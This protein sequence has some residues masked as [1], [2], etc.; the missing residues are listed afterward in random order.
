MVR[1]RGID[2]ALHLIGEGYASGGP[3]EVWARQERL[4][5]GVAFLGT[6]PREELLARMGRATVLAHASREEAFGMTLVEAMSQRLPVIAGVRSGA[7]PWVLGGGRAGMLVDVKDAGVLADA[8][9]AVLLQPER[10]EGLAR[11]GYEYAWNNY[12]QSR[13]ADLYLDVYRRVLVDAAHR[14]LTRG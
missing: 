5:D 12:R 3:C 14:G 6:L 11:Q 9:A 4:A 8:I 10:R 1:Q 2:C 13:V 7:V